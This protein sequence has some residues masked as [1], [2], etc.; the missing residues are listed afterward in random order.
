MADKILQSGLL[1]FNLSIN[2][3]SMSR[4]EFLDLTICFKCYK[5]NDH[6]ANHCGQGVDYKI[7]SLCSSTDH[8]YRECKS[9]FN[10]C[11]NCSV[12]HK[13][14]SFACPVRKE[15]Y[16]SVRASRAGDPKA[17]SIVNVGPDTRDQR[18]P[19]NNIHNSTVKAAMCLLIASMEGLQSSTE[20]EKTVNTLLKANNLPS[21]TLAGLEPPLLDISSF[22]L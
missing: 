4:E 13:T 7:C 12:D 8:T 11:V 18:Q 17:G 2:P 1:L 10:K 3:S 19:Q 22:E 9:E 5:W 16:R 15:I 21:I 14:I 20:Y 6:I